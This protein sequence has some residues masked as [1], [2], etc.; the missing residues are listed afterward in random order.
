MAIEHIEVMLTAVWD[1]ITRWHRANAPRALGSLHPPATPDILVSVERDLGLQ[2][3]S[4]LRAS[5]SL[6]DGGLDIDGFV[7]LSAS[8][9]LARWR[10]MEQNRVTGRYDNIETRPEGDGVLQAGWWH[11]EWIP[12]AEES[13]GDFLCTDTTPAAQGTPGQVIFIGEEGP[14]PTLDRSYLAWLERF[15]DDLID[16][17]MSVDA[18]G[19]VRRR[20]PVP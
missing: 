2:F 3:P 17:M 12:F 19:F 13:G 16:G 8:N 15:R 5:L 6:Y 1:D 7:T 9:L 11:P 4:D 10:I 20:D 18:E 14:V